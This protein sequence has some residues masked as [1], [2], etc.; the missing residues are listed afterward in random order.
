MDQPIKLPVTP[1]YDPARD[2]WWLADADGNRVPHGKEQVEY[3][4]ELLNSLG[5]RS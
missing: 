2:T 1:R 5:D 4:A 3:L